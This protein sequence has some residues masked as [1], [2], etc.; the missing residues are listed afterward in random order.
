[1]PFIPD[2]FDPPRSA[3]LPSIFLD[4]LRPAHADAD[5]EAVVAS[6]DA[7]RGT[8]GPGDETWPSPTIS[9][10]EN[11]AD[12]TRHEREFRERYAFAYA[13]FDASRQKY[14]G[15]FYLKPIK[16]KTLGNQQQKLFTAQAFLWLSVLHDVL[17]DEACLIEIADWIDSVWDL[18][19]VAW[20]GRTI[21]WIEWRN[22]SE[23]RA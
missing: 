10:A 23:T 7:I 15:C 17:S 6:G 19:R 2:V 1:M 21:S 22:L 16:S 18:H 13:I 11:L 5:Y 14:L 3:S 4:V 20:P 8:F 9:Y 12:L